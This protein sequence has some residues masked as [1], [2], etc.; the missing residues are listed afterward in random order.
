MSWATPSA[1]VALSS[2]SAAT[3]ANTIDNL[4]FAQTW[5][6]NSLS[7]NAGM[8]F[9]SN[10]TAAGSNLQTLVNVALSGANATA[11]QTTYGLQV[12]NTHTGTSSTNVGMSVSASGGTNNYALVVPAGNVGVNTTAPNTSLDVDGGVSV[13]PGT[14]SVTAD[15]Q[16]IT[17]GNRSF[18]R[19]TSNS[20]P[21]NRTIT[22][23]NGL[24]DGQ[25]LFIRVDGSGTAGNGVEIADSGSCNLSGIAQ[26]IDSSVIQLI[27]DG[28]AS[29]WFEVTR[30]L[31]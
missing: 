31:N 8:T 3:A 25:L 10:S 29:K 4:G 24:Q 11:S 14:V 17:V 1:S 6:W 30:S 21:T 16:A 5:Q 19:L 9:S 2:I 18:I 13:R 28:S 20:T 26:L 23:S 7:T 22:L 12:S 27:W 15:N